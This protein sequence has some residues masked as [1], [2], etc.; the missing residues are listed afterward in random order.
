MFY[1]SIQN[2]MRAR[3]VIYKAIEID[4]KNGFYDDK[5]GVV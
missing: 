4:I 3:G 2:T 5:Y 1:G